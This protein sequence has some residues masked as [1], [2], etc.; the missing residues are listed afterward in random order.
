MLNIPNL[1]SKGSVRVKYKDDLCTEL[2]LKLSFESYWFFLILSSHDA[3]ESYC[4]QKKFQ[5]I[6]F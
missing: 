5:T 1:G 6:T 3:F 4:R 2:C